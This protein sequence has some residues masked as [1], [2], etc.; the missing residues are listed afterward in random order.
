MSLADVAAVAGFA[1]QAHLN[2]ESRALTG[3]L[4]SVFL[5]TNTWSR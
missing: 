5:A 1:D 3:Q 4:P 2:R